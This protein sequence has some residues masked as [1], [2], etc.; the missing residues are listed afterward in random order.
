MKELRKKHEEKGLI[1]LV[2]GR[3]GIIER[4]N[5]IVVSYVKELKEAGA[6]GAI[7]GGGLALANT[8]LEIQ[9]LISKLGLSTK[10]SD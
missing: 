6:M 9:Q 5:D 1:V 4:T 10:E 8:S 7:V 2:E 3:I